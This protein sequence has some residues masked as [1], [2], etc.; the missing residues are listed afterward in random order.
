MPQIHFLNVREG[1][2]NVIQHNSGHVT[3]IDVCNAAP[4]VVVPDIPVILAP[5]ASLRSLL[6]APPP[7]PGDFGQRDFPV[8]PIGY[9]NAHKFLGHKQQQG[10]RLEQ[11]T[12]RQIQRGGLEILSQLERWCQRPQKP[13]T[14]DIVLGL[15]EQVLQRRGRWRRWRGRPTYPC[16]N[17]GL[18]QGR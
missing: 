7:L 4:V 16:S 1:D 12:T 11:E 2:C 9:L 6:G 8:N 5:K 15:Q 10:N 14:I 18:D 3:V 17:R 13:N